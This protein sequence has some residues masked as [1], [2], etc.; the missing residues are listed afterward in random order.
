MYFDIFIKV[1]DIIDWEYLD[2][3]INSVDAGSTAFGDC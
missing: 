2:L 1:L 3:S